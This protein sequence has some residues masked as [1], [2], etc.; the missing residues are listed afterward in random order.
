MSKIANAIHAG[1]VEVDGAAGG[2]SES[3]AILEKTRL[4]AMV[5]NMPATPAVLLALEWYSARQLKMGR[6][7]YAGQRVARISANALAV[8]TGRPVRTVRAALSK[9]KRYDLIE[10]VATEIGCTNAYRVLA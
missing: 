4:E 10:T 6:G 2:S 8:L 9:L 3:Y 1:W 5:Q 7:E